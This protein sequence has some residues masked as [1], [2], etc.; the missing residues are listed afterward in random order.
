MSIVEDTLSGALCGWFDENERCVHVDERLSYRQRRC[1]LAHELW[2]AFFHHESTV[3]VYAVKDELRVRRLTARLLIS[4]DQYAMVEA[5][6]DA[7]PYAMAQELEVTLQVLLD[8]QSLLEEH[9][10]LLES[11]VLCMPIAAA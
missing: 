2:H 3:H 7:E 10:R 9:P 8:F 1:V 6:F 5:M 11:E 4:D